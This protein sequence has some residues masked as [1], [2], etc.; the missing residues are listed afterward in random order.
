VC[1]R[2]FVRSVFAVT[3]AYQFT[4]YALDFS[5]LCPNLCSIAS[6][7]TLASLSWL[8]LCSVSFLPWLCVFV[9]VYQPPD[10]HLQLWARQAS[11]EERADLTAE[12]D[13][14]GVTHECTWLICTGESDALPLASLSVSLAPSDTAN[15]WISE[16]ERE[17]RVSAN[18]WCSSSRCTGTSAPI[19]IQ[20]ESFEHAASL[21]A[22]YVIT[23]HTRTHIHITSHTHA[24][25]CVLAARVPCDGCLFSVRFACATPDGHFLRVDAF[26]S[27]LFVHLVSPPCLLHS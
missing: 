12:V 2:Y 3:R 9:C 16:V 20:Y 23:H 11:D 21:V 7:S 14:Q 17:E 26:L 13:Q 5:P 25:H 8:S 10:D 27:P 15:A 22:R 18:S 1:V 19:T 24:Y 4:F 6:H